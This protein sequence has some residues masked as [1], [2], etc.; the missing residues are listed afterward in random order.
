MT[1]QEARRQAKVVAAADAADPGLDTLMD[2]ALTDLLEE[3]VN[4]PDP[5]VHAPGPLGESR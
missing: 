5:L 3:E 2:A 4:P 1:D